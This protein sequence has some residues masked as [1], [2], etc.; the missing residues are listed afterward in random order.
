[1]GG[2]HPLFLFTAESIRL[3]GEIFIVSKNHLV[4]PVSED[5]MSPV[6]V[7][8][9]LKFDTPHEYEGKEYITYYYNGL[10]SNGEEETIAAFGGL[11]NKIK[12]TGA[13]KGSVIQIVRFGEGKNTIW[14]VK[15]MNPESLLVKKD[16]SEVDWLDDAPVERVSPPPP[17]TSANP[18]HIH[19]P[20]RVW[21]PATIDEKDV[22]M[23]M[24]ENVLDMIEA[25]LTR[26]DNREAFTD[27]SIDQ[28]VRLAITC[29]IESGRKYKPGMVM[30]VS[31]DDIMDD[32]FDNDRPTVVGIGIEDFAREVVGNTSDM[33]TPEKVI[34]AVVENTAFA[35]RNDLVT[36]MQSLGLSSD[37]ITDE[38]DTWYRV[39][40]I[41]NEWMKNLNWG[42]SKEDVSILLKDNISKG[43]I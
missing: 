41:A 8:F 27:V 17:V 36:M 38:P 5:P 11:H 18:N 4:I 13:A 21:T 6:P 42:H 29:H 12:E 24:G 30:P 2:L 22:R 23:E 16:H 26:V 14:N 33:T 37:F 20:T 39:Y 40:L 31:T 10:N 28:K 19:R 3:Q 15:V 32:L 9:E 43:V 34:K 1:M 35:T 25:Y 7:I